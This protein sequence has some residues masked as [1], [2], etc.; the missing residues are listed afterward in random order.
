[1]HNA[2]IVAKVD[3]VRKHPNADRL[4]IASILGTQVVVGLDTQAG[5]IGIYFDSN[6]QLSEEFATANNLIRIKNEDGTMSGGMFD[7]NRRVRAMNLRGVKSDGFYCPMSYFAFIDDPKI[8]SLPLGAALTY[9]QRADGENFPICNKYVTPQ[10]ARAIAAREH[11]KPRENKVLNFPEHFDTEQY[12]Y[13]KDKITPNSFLIITEKLHGTS[14]RYGN[15]AHTR[16]LTW[17]EKIAQFFGIPV[18][19]IEYKHVNGTRRVVMADNHTGYYSNEQFRYNATN[20]ITLKEDEIIYGEL[21]G[22]TTTGAAIMGDHDP[23]KV[24]KEFAKLYPK[25][26]RYV[27]GTAQG[28]CKLF[29]YRVTQDG[30]DLSWF[31]IVARCKELGLNHVPVLWYDI[32]KDGIELEQINVLI[33]Q[34]AQGVSTLDRSHVRE[35]V[36]IR[37]ENETGMTVLKEKS[38]EFK[39]MEGIVKSNDDFVD[40]EE[41]A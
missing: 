25:T 33:E 15:V 4:Q 1:M 11:N 27:Y 39:V 31:Q 28:E 38:Y 22:Y 2:A 36:C 41:I 9:W 19:T 8:M 7:T 20:G 29:V 10:T 12:R 32:V 14:M 23:S 34:F 30:K 18:S 40:T 6:L 21:V 17:K 35:G 16:K 37:I 13:N 5:D 26:M 24:S 3:S